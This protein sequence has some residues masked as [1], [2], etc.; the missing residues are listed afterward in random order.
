MTASLYAPMP[1][2]WSSQDDWHWW[3][4]HNDQVTRD[5]PRRPPEN[6]CADCTPEFKQ[7]QVVA[8]RC[9]YPKVY[10]VPIIERQYEPTLHAR[11]DVK[12]NALR[13]VP[14]DKA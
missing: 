14:D 1:K 11:R 12:T 10:F 5:N 9:A 13:G 7:Q 8:G 4:K 3:N 6:F 2:C